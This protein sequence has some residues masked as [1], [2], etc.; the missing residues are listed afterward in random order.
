LPIQKYDGLENIEK[1]SRH[2]YKSLNTLARRSRRSFSC[3]LARNLLFRGKLCLLRYFL[4]ELCIIQYT[5][6]IWNTISSVFC[7][8]S[9]NHSCH[10]LL[11]HWWHVSNAPTWY[12]SC[13]IQ[14]YSTHWTRRKLHTA[15]KALVFANRPCKRAWS[16]RLAIAYNQWVLEWWR[17]TNCIWNALNLVSSVFVHVL[18]NIYKT[19]NCAE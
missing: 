13:R 6:Y 11:E 19:R 2:W 7:S 8:L 1:P 5:N 4:Y 3:R 18:F 9:K 10:Y 14:L 12:Y 17:Y 15:I 16:T